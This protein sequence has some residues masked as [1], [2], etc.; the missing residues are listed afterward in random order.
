MCNAECSRHLSCWLLLCRHQR[1]MQ[2]TQKLRNKR[3]RGT[4][5]QSVITLGQ[6]VWAWMSISI[7]NG[8]LCQCSYRSIWSALWQ[9]SSLPTAF[10]TRK[11]ER[12]FHS[13]NS[14]LH[15]RL[16][17][18]GHLYATSVSVQYISNLFHIREVAG[19]NSGRWL[20]TAIDVPR[21]LQ[22]LKANTETVPNNTPR[23]LPFTFEFIT[24]IHS[25]IRKYT[26]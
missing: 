7:Y 5:T 23:P 4:M 13:S 14:H 21:F 24:R 17:E 18:V 12:T 6:W 3:G 9:L 25:T 10:P 20:T 2:V 22:S 8:W 15:Y 11:H 16:T 26:G 19:S 1:Q